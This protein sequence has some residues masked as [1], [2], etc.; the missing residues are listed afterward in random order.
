MKFSAGKTTGMKTGSGTITVQRSGLKSLTFADVL[1]AATGASEADAA[2]IV[3]ALCD[4]G[5]IRFLRPT[6]QHDVDRLA[7]LVHP[8]H[9]ARP[10]APPTAGAA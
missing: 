5:R 4:S 3:Q 9:R 2:A 1:N 6:A 7:R 8:D 10:S